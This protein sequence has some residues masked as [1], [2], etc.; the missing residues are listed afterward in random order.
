[1]VNPEWELLKI[2]QQCFY[3]NCWLL[4]NTSRESNG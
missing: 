4:I 2:R 3:S 1:M